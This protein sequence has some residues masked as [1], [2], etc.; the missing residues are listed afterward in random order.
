MRSALI[1]LVPASGHTKVVNVKQFVIGSYRAHDHDFSIL[2]WQ[3]TNRG[4]YEVVRVDLLHWR[5]LLGGFNKWMVS[6]FFGWSRGLYPVDVRHQRIAVVAFHQK[7]HRHVWSVT[8]FNNWRL[9]SY[10][11]VAYGQVISTHVRIDRC[12]DNSPLGM[13]EF[14]FKP[15]VLNEKWLAFSKSLRFFLFTFQILSPQTCQFL[16]N[17]IYNQNLIIKVI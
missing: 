16:A 2:T 9:K 13:C 1:F 11:R 6:I 7:K 14:F 3:G 5:S 8:H 12:L 17:I 4:R 15:R 10:G